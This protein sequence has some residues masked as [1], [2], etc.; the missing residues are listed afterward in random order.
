MYISFIKVYVKYLSK[1]WYFVNLVNLNI[2]SKC[3]LE[4][5]LKFQGN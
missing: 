2:S 5:L 4:T 1:G 3:L